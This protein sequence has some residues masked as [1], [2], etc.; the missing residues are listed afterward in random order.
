ILSLVDDAWRISLGQRLATGMELSLD[1]VNDRSL[2]T[3]GTAVAPLNY[4][5]TLSIGVRQPLLRGFS[6]DLDIP[7][8]TILQARLGSERERQQL[9]IVI[10]EVVERTE[11][12]YW[13]V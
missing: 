6:L 7:R 13:D 12:A 10:A 9:A 5:S 2:S 4:R 1:F 8:Y 3:L 11:A